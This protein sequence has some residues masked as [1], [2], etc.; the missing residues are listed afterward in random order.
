MGDGDEDRRLAETVLESIRNDDGLSAY[1]INVS[2]HDGVVRL[3]GI[4]DVLAEKMRAEEVAAKVEGVVAVENDLTVCT[5]GQITDDDVDFE[6]SEEL[7]LDPQ[8]NVARIYAESKRGVV[9]LYGEADS[10]DRRNA[11][12]AAAARAR[13]VK[14]IVSH[15]KVTGEDERGGPIEGDRAGV[16]GTSPQDADLH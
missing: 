11:A 16:K 7:R 14:D 12:V 13:G 2:A 4:V 3:G 8:V 6:V 10:L 5:D 9:H 1:E 15:I